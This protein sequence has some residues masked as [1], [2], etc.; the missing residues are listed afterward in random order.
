MSSRAFVRARLRWAVVLFM[1]GEHVNVIPCVDGLIPGAW[2]VLGC[3]VQ[4]C[5]TCLYIR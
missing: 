1:A 3:V 2:V 5:E 4:A